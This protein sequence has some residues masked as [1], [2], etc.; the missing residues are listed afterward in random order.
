MASGPRIII[1]ATVAFSLVAG[2]IATGTH[3]LS[4][5]KRQ[6]TLLTSGLNLSS[7]SL[8]QLHREVLR[9]AIALESNEP[10]VSPNNEAI[11]LQI[12]LVAS[13]VNAI[14]KHHVKVSLSPELNGHISDT[15]IQCN[16]T[17]DLLKDWQS[18]DQKPASSL[19]QLKREQFRRE[20]LKRN[21]VE[22]LKSLE[23]DLNDAK[24]LL[25]HQHNAQ[26]AELVVARSNSLRLLA[27]VSL[28]LLLFLLLVAYLTIQ[29][30]Q[31]RQK[32]LSALNDSEAQ[33]RRIVE[34][35]AEGIWLFD[36]QGKSNF[37]NQKI[38]EM[39]G[40]PSSEA[41]LSRSFFDFFDSEF[42]VVAAKQH[43]EKL[44]QG[45]HQPCDLK[46][47]RHN[48]EA[49]W[50]L[51][52]ST[53][54]L[55]PQTEAIAGVL[56]MLTDITTRKGIE[57]ELQYAKQKAEMASLAKS[58]FLANM[59]HELRTP[60]NGILGY[61]QILSRSQS[62]GKQEHNGIQVISQ[63]GQHLLT[64]INDILD[65]SK[66]E[67]RKLDLQPQAIHLS[68][69]LQGIIEIIKIRAQQ[70][71]L[72]I[73]YEETGQL[74]IAIEADE[75][76]L[77]QVLI[78]LLGNAVKFTDQGFVK[79]AIAQHSDAT[80]LPNHVTLH[81]QVQDTGVGMSPEHLEAIFQPFEQVGDAQKQSEGT[82]LGLSISQRIINLMGS[83]IQVSSQLGS[84]STFSFEVVLPISP[85]W[86]TRQHETSSFI[87]GYKGTR[88]T[89]LSID[90]HW[91]NRE[92]LAGLLTPLG[93]DVVDAVHGQDGLEKARDIQ[94]DLIIT[95]LSMPV[96]DGH[97]L[98]KALRHDPA[99]QSIKV[100]V[101]S[102]SVGQ[103]ERDL[104]S[105]AGADAFISKPVQQDILLT[106]LAE[107]LELTW[108]Y[109]TTPTQASL[110]PVVEFN[111]DTA[112]VIPPLPILEEL[113]KLAQWGR[114]QKFTRAAERLY[115][116]NSSYQAFIYP[117]LQLANQFELETIETILIEQIRLGSNISRDGGALLAPPSR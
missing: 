115:E 117:L 77:R 55:N 70:K 12:N 106:T 87:Q 27:I 83:Q 7:H 56:S 110:E 28:L 19:D 20:Q 67:A 94:P 58:E 42:Q 32:V 101:T 24:R 72:E 26:Y 23:L 34:T 45:E 114:A 80:L 89:I 51:I 73:I 54:I 3:L 103:S 104:C 14:Q 10:E 109:A 69:F 59:S 88:K 112:S 47:R 98:L 2:I 21:I 35:S 1:I 60:L 22:R 30:T 11:R 78:N 41:V 65:L 102:A 85:E 86:Q 116:E 46:L 31:E 68:S 82:G 62:W 107:Q 64:L 17:L 90:D 105:T 25:L 71:G 75:K 40:L 113:L 111:R 84:G 33:Y 43:F 37:V 92:V 100:I 97:S 50:I 38:I 36:D 108:I 48:G 63:C 49:L 96:M 5:I 91:Q 95:D 66:I 13:R 79:L 29:F 81:V 52:H 53:L 44:Y 61:A 93:F 18:T 8:G 6:D 16:S 15:I 99:L 57:E 76:R 4:Q 39:L 9:L 74:P